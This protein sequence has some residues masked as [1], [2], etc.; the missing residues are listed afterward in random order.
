VPKIALSAEGKNSLVANCK[1]GNNIFEHL[2]VL[3]NFWSH[4]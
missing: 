4:N 1:Y 2:S 3:S